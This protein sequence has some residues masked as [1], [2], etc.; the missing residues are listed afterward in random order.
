MAAGLVVLLGL[1]QPAASQFELLEGEEPGSGPSPSPATTEQVEPAPVIVDGRT[2]FEIQTKLGN[3]IPQERAAQAAEQIVR[4]AADRELASDRLTT[5]PQGDILLIAVTADTVITRI[6]QLDA[7]L[8]NVSQQTLADEYIPAIEQ[9]IMDYRRERSSAYLLR[10]LGYTT[11]ALVSL[12]AAIWIL[13]RL[14]RLL[15]NR[16]KTMRLPTIT[17]KEVEILPSQELEATLISFIQSIQRFMIVIAM[18]VVITL[19]SNLFP[20]TRVLYSGVSDYFS[21]LPGTVSSAIVNY[22]PKLITLLLILTLTQSVRGFINP[23]FDKISAGAIVIPGFYREWAEPTHR[24]LDVAIIVLTAVVCFP[25]IPGSDS[26]AFRGASLFL[27]LVFSLGSTSAIGNL[28]AGIILIYTR[29]Y[30]VG[31][32]VQIGDNVGIVSEKALVVTRLRTSNN[33]IVTIPNGMLLSD[34]AVEVINDSISQR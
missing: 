30:Q 6:T 10:S 14:N 7:E 24:L 1:H 31:D 34:D 3:T 20:W 2:L 32:R 16:L 5:I 21:E 9:A 26:P 11:I 12:S 25:Y 29:P 8:A 18:I 17:I 22:I 15:I 33:E 27:G 23:F 19:V 28:I 4:V 13:I